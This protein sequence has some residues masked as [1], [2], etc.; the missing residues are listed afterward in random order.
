MIVFS[1]IFLENSLSQKVKFH[2]SYGKRLINI[3]KVKY[4]I[5]YFRVQLTKTNEGIWI[6]TI[7][8]VYKW[9]LF[10]LLAVDK[11]KILV[12]VVVVSVDNTGVTLKMSK[13]S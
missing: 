2:F 4:W 1:G 9:D 7:K 10:V 13:Y 11:L 8:Y 3:F 12:F 5:P 6:D